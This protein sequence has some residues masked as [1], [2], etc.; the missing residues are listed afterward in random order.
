MTAGILTSIRKRDLLKKKCI[1]NRNNEIINQ[2]YRTYRNTLTSLIKSIT[3]DALSTKW[4]FDAA[5]KA[6][7]KWLPPDVEKTVR[8][9]GYYSVLVKPGFRVIGINSNFCF[10][11]NLWLFYEDEDPYGQLTWLVQE[12]LKAEKNHEKVHILSHVPSGHELCHVQWSK[13]YR[14]IVER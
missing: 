2:E 5:W 14:R 4:I 6:W 8:H 11:H 12:L 13:N 3:E 10:V 1:A 7:S 9:A